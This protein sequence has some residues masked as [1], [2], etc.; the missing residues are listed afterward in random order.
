MERKVDRKIIFVGVWLERR[1]EG[2][3]DGGLGV[4]F[5]DS[6]KFYLSNLERK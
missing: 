3:I 4:S 1:K 2:Q 6:T 5:S